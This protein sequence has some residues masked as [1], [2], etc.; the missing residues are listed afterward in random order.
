MDVRVG[1]KRRLSTKE[2]MLS[3][4]GAREDSW[5]SHGQQGNWIINPKENQPWIPIG[6]TVAEEEALILWPYDAKSRLIG[7]DPDAGKDWV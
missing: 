2:L 3:N 4:C 1:P 7:K 6:R 5:E